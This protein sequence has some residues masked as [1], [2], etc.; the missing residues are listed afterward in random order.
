MKRLI[1]ARAEMVDFANKIVFLKEYS[2][3][4]YTPTR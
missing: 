3:D 4:G 2:R 1:T